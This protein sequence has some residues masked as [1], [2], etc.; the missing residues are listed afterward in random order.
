MSAGTAIR[1]GV[2][3]Y[4]QERMSFRDTECGV[5][6][7]PEPPSQAGYIYVSV[8]LGQ[9]NHRGLDQSIQESWGVDVT[10]SLKTARIPFQRWGIDAIDRPIDGLEV[11]GTQILNLLH[12]NYDLMNAINASGRNLNFYRPLLAPSTQAAPQE[13]G[14]AWWGAG[15]DSK[16]GQAQGMS[17]TFRFE[18]AERIS[19]RGEI[20]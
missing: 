5:Q 3:R 6:N 16:G 12:H 15:K 8:H 4:L 18:G 17:K 20:E 2:Q 13:R 11:L 9:E 19:V 7:G 1:K 14:G 10:V